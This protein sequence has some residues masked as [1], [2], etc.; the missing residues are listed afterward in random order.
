MVG[1]KT[2]CSICYEDLNPIIEDLQ[3]VTICGHVFHELCLQQW[4]EY[5]KNGIKKNCP[6]CKQACSEENATRLYFQSIGD[7]NDTNLTQKPRD[8]GEDHWELRNEVKRL[9][10]KVLRLTSTLEKQLNDLK[11]INAELFTCKEELKMEVTLKTE[12]LKQGAAIQQLLHLKSKELHRSTL[13]CTRLQD[14]NLA[15]AKE[16]ATLKLVCDSSLEEEEVLKLASL[17]NDVNSRETIDVLKKSLV[18]RNKSYEELMTKCNTLDRKEARSV[19]KLKKA[20]EKKNKLKARVQELEMALEGKHKEILRISRASKKNYQGSKEPKVDRCSYE[21]QN[22]APAETKA[23]LCIFTSSCDDLSRPRRKRKCKSKD[24]STLNMAE[25]IIPSSLHKNSH[26]KD[27]SIRNKDGGTSDTSTY[28]HEVSNQNLHQSFDHKKSVHDS[29][30]STPGS[31]NCS[32][33]TTENMPPVIILD[34]DDTDLPPLDDI[35]QHQPSFH[36]RKETSSAVVLAQPGFYL[37][38]L[39][40]K[41]LSVVWVLMGLTGTWENGVRESKGERIWITVLR[42]ATIRSSETVVH[43]SMH[44]IFLVAYYGKVILGVWSV[45]VNALNGFALAIRVFCADHVESS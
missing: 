2:I 43:A 31:R 10:G 38:Q 12:A 33:N 42:T 44:F 40:V 35:T 45:F 11:E 6:V 8:Y 19:R 26:E 3:S 15:L 17:G 14:R 13:E 30:L 21:N 22:M 36:I 25:D 9:E 39:D 34:D 32:K 37:C 7:P 23:D 1:V 28:L 16:L 41:V 27:T 24:K 20:K 18:I 5:C 29:F 4:F